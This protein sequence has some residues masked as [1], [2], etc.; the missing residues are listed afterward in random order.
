[1]DATIVL[2]VINGISFV[3]RDEIMRFP[4]LG[5][6]GLIQDSPTQDRQRR[7][8]DRSKLFQDTGWYF[9][10]FSS[11]FFGTRQSKA[12]EQSLMISN[13]RSHAK[14]A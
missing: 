13:R 4:A 1:M 12:N 8:D 7:R 2:G 10:S 6:G 11:G 9:V 5:P 14:F 3:H